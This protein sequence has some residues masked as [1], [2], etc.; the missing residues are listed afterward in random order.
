MVGVESAV[1]PAFSGC[2]CTPDPAALS[3]RHVRALRLRIRRC[4]STASWQLGVYG[5]EST[6]HIESLARWVPAPAR[7]MRAGGV[8]EGRRGDRT[9]F[10]VLTPALGACRMTAA[11]RT[12]GETAVRSAI[13]R[14]AAAGTGRQ[15]LRGGRPPAQRGCPSNEHHGGLSKRVR[16]DALATIDWFQLS[17][18]RAEVSAVSIDTFITC[19]SPASRPAPRLARSHTQPPGSGRGGGRK[20]AVLSA[21]ARRPCASC[22]WSTPLPAALSGLPRGHS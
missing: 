21:R 19:N 20:V 8:R 3:A 22:V 12:N 15:R 2:Q 1:R 4:W 13:W 11:E 5:S 10:L 7:A 6:H 9:W 17:L 14:R 18:M 16:M